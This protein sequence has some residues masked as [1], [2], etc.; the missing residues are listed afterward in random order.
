MFSRLFL[1]PEIFYSGTNKAGISKFR[2]PMP[3]LGSTYYSI[4]ILGSLQS[5]A[6]A[7]N[8]VGILNGLSL[9]FFM[10]Y[11]LQELRSVVIVLDFILYP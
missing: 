8:A 4:G 10:F 9:L 6:L 11:F 3:V 5:F 2:F 7:S 1:S